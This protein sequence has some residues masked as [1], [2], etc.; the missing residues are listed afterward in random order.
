MKWTG[1]GEHTVFSWG[2]NFYDVIFANPSNLSTNCLGFNTG[3]G[4]CWG[5]PNSTLNGQWIYLTMEFFNGNKQGSNLYINGIKQVVTQ[6]SGG[7]G[8][9]SVQDGRATVGALNA[10]GYNY[11]GS[12]DE[13]RVSSGS[14]SLAWNA[15]DYKSASNAF[16]TQ[17]NPESPYYPSGNIVSNIYDLTFGGDWGVLSYTTNNSSK[18][19]V[20]VRTSNNSDM[21]GASAFAGCPEISSGTDLTGKTCVNNNDRYAQYQITLVND[22]GDT[23]IFQDIAL[24]YDAWDTN[25]P[26][27]NADSI[28]M[29]K[30]SGGDSISSNGWTNGSTPYFEWTPGTDV[31]GGSGIKGYCL[32]LGQDSTADPVTTKG[33]L[34]TS[35][36]NTNGA[37]QF[38]VSGTNIDTATANYISSALSSSDNP[39]Y[40]NVKAID[41]ANN[42]FA[43]NS[44]QFQFKFDNTLPTNPTFVTAPSQ[45][46]A[47]KDV[48]FT[49]PT[50]GGDAPSDANSGIKG[51]QYRIGNNGTWYGDAHSGAQDINDLLV[52][53][54]SYT[55]INN[56][57]F[58]NISEGNNIVYFRTWDNA[59]NI[60][61]T[62]VTTVIKLNTTSPSSPQ[63]VT[64]TPSTNTTNSFAFSW[65]APSAFQGT[66]G[67]LT[68]C[69]TVNTLP[70]ANTCSYT[71]A[72][73]TSLPAGAYATQPGANTFYV[74]AK[75]EAGNINYATAASDTFTAN[76]AAPGVPLDLD[77]ADVSTKATSTWR[78]ALS[79]NA[80]TNAGAGVSNYRVYRSNDNTSFSE[81]ATTAGTSYVDGNLGPQKYYYKL[82]ACDSANNCGAYS[83][84]VNKL[85]TGKFTTAANITAQPRVINIST[86]KATVRWSTDRTSNSR[87]S[88]GTKTGEY[89]PFQVASEQQVTDHVVDLTN[90][91]AGTTYF[92]K[93]SWTDEDGNTGLSSE[94]S[95]KTQDAPSTQEVK[96]LSIG[97]SSAQIQFTSVSAA[98][99]VIQYGKSDGFG[100]VKEVATSLSRSTYT[101]DLAGLDDGTK[102]LY[103][104]NTY[105]ADGNE[106]VGSTVLNFTTPARPRISNLRF[107]PVAGE[108]TSTQEVSW[109][110]NV[111]AS[112]QI[113]YG[114]VGLVSKEIVESQL[115]TDHK[116]T[117]TGLED[118]SDYT[119]IAQSRDQGGN[120]AS[121]DSQDF[122][123]ALDTRPPKI[124]D[125]SVESSIKGTGAEARGQI[126]VSWKTD[127]P[128][129]SQVAYAEG[130]DVKEFNNRS[131]QDG[132]LTTEHLV[133]VSD[134]QT[135][136]LYSVQPVSQ[137]RSANKGSGDIQS[138]IIGKASDSVLTIILTTL[139]GIFGF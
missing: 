33:N 36:L 76:T 62:N 18:T 102:Y 107:Q 72:G 79:W 103:R 83:S 37:C 25:P 94:F 28:V 19:S 92:A 96:A 115:I 40:L 68:Y 57:D 70:S 77:I 138:A 101:L 60:S 51:L 120:L 93:A 10:Y 123:T 53:D 126:V 88:L 61:T 20:K 114:K 87:I 29:K 73:V 106:Y 27:N 55:T 35:P 63:N 5:V 59:G 136:K 97:L 109:T 66:A 111:P 99:V 108:P 122:K 7:S 52:N 8:F 129:T 132:K 24:Q 9:Q 81:V 2:N 125:I 65:A 31:S 41:N 86:K 16:I 12:M 74:V 43:G 15:A 48:T 118:D 89:A 133:I 134:L 21:S 49:W 34:G 67:N 45:F 47:T 85:P 128:A 112:S 119:L 11:N 30:A 113:V 105:D 137:D 110:T 64:A 127:E 131:T 116:I 17:G 13:L 26:D 3:Q 80:P 75:D 38:A 42:V 117:I 135:S 14:R 95:F 23:P 6:R 32:Y 58:A 104:L 4:D 39:Y 90:L 54:G 50:T 139:K 1:G 124:S 56:P 100:G 46:V 98:K 44:T 121:S 84:T 82:K 91:S 78:L 71:L 22:A 130:S 69:Y